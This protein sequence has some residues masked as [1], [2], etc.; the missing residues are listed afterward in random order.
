MSSLTSREAIRSHYGEPSSGAVRKQLDRLDRHAR[1]FIA[2][3]PFM[4]IASAD[5][6]GN[7]DATPRG[8][9]P[10]FV[11]VADEHTLLIPD[12]PGNNRVDTLLNLAENPRLGL[13]FFVP[14][15]IETLRVNGQAQITLEAEA[16]A[17]LAHDGKP[18]RAA[19][20]LTVEEC[21]FHCG[22][23]LIR[24]G[25]WA[26]RPRPEFPRFG[27][28]LADQIAGIDAEATEDRLQDAYRNRLY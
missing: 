10:G 11:A 15:V 28:V 7:C 9:G 8:D 1:A 4:V 18:P 25:L 24:S 14:G 20:R 17:L 22:K 13:L 3:S 23:A 27:Q 16:L 21:F 5:G 6:A 26:D 12:R 2:L 19:I